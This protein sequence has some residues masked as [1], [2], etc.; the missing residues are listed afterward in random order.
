MEPNDI[1]GLTEQEAKKQSNIDELLDDNDGT[2]LQ[3]LQV[4]QKY[5][6]NKQRLCLYLDIDDLVNL[7]VRKTVI[8]ESGK[9]RKMNPAVMLN[10]DIDK[11]P[12]VRNGVM[13]ELNLHLGRQGVGAYFPFKIRKTGVVVPAAEP[14]Q[15]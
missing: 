15:A 7:A 1:D 14:Q 2:K 13:Y 4:D 3:V 8:D 5:D 11:L 6:E 12:F 9:K 10:A